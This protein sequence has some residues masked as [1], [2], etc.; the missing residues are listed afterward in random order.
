MRGELTQARAGIVALREAGK[1]LRAA[2]QELLDWDGDPDE[3]GLATMSA[4]E[5]TKAYGH[6]DEQEVLSRVRAALRKW[7]KVSK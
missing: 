4:P 1:K 7:E 5:F 2:T 3:D 6:E